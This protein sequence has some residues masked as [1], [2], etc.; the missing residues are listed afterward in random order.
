LVTQS[1]SI[2]ALGI[3][4]LLAVDI[5]KEIKKRYGVK[6][7]AAALYELETVDALADHVLTH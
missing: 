1:Q 4:S 3:D 6:I 2:S 7:K 5:T